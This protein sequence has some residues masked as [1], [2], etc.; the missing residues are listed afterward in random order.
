M[1]NSS[2]IRL[3]K[4]SFHNI[5]HYSLKTQPTDTFSVQD[6]AVAL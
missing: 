1:N 6:D 4:L 2:F 3:I 5:C